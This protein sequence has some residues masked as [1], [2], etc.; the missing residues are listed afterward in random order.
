MSRHTRDYMPEPVAGAVVLGYRTADYETLS[1]EGGARAVRKGSAYRK[2]D[3][4][5]AFLDQKLILVLGV[6]TQA[7]ESKG[8]VIPRFRVQ[9]ATKKGLWSQSWLYCF[10]G[11]IY[12]AHFDDN[13]DLRDGMKEESQDDLTAFVRESNRIEGIE[14]E[15]SDDEVSALES[16]LRIDVIEVRHL[17]TLVSVFEPGARLRE[18]PGM[19]VRV[20]NHIAPSGGPKI[21]NALETLLQDVKD[22]GASHYKVHRA[23]NPS[24]LHRWQRALGAGIVALDDEPGSRRRTAGLSSHVL[25]SGA[26]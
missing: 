1:R 19:N 9:H 25:L 8:F 23:Y 12:R 18:M 13:G 14:R 20:G 7:L 5:H 4:T 11:D 2:G 24:P 16:F 22:S 10:P 3:V 21:R 17:E 15:P 6:N 26:C